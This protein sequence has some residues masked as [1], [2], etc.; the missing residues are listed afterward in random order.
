MSNRYSGPAA[1]ADVLELLTQPRHQPSTPAPDQHI[2]QRLRTPDDSA[3]PFIIKP[4]AEWLQTD[5]PYVTEAPLFGPFWNRGEVCILFA[6]TNV[7]KSILAVQIAD[8]LTKAQPIPGFDTTPRPETVLY[9]DFEL[10]APQFT[11]RYTSDL[12]GHYPFAP[13]FARLV[14]NPLAEGEDEFDSYTDYLN[15]AIEDVLTATGARFII[16]DNITCLNS[17][18]QSN[19]TA[20]NLMKKLQQIK[21]LYGL[22]ILVL[23]HTP[24]RN[25]SRPITHNCLQGSKMLINFADSAFAI[26]HSQSQTDVRYLKQIKQRSGRQLYGANR[27]CLCRIV[28]PGN[29]LHMEFLGHG[30]ESDH[31]LHYTE[32]QRKATEDRVAQLHANGLSLRAIAAQTGISCATVFRLVRRLTRVG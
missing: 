25:P 12:H 30:P 29:F 26:G 3:E 28:K 10:T 22:S 20:I 13:G 32:H 23:A 19:V 4:A 24:K 31:L 14:F 1:G 6:D 18:T 7:G 15:N 2:I 21:R 17:G 5:S 27:V 9:F 11:Q 8:A 16:I